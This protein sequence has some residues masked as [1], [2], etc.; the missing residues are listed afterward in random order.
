MIQNKNIRTN[1]EFLKRRQLFNSFPYHELTP[2]VSR[3]SLRHRSDHYY[4]DFLYSVLGNPDPDFIPSTTY[5]VYIEP[6]LNNF[7]LLAAVTDKN[8][9]DQF[10][11]DIR[12]PHTYLRKLNDNFY[13]QT[14]N[15]VDLTNTYLN[16]L[17]NDEERL[18][19]KPSIESGGGRSIMLF[20]RAGREL[21]SD[22]ICL[23]VDL[24][25]GFPD[26]VLQKSVV[27]HDYFRHFNPDSNNT[28][29]ILTYRSVVD[30]RIYLLHRLLRIGRRGSFLDH[31]NLGGIVIGIKESGCL[32]AFGCTVMG[33]KLNTFNGVDFA[34]E[35]KVPF[36]SQIEEMA[37]KIAQQIHYGRLLALDFTVDQTGN[38]LFLEVNCRWNGIDQYQM[39]LGS[40]FGR[41]T[42]EV[43]NY[44]LEKD[45]QYLNKNIG[46]RSS[47]PGER[48]GI[49]GRC[50]WQRTWGARN[51]FPNGERRFKNMPPGSAWNAPVVSR[52]GSETAAFSRLPGWS[53]EPQRLLAASCDEEI[54]SPR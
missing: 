53:P 45:C 34:E 11:A 51:F 29:R 14:F 8:F 24:L 28:I 32:N 52:S 17:L 25:A 31:D 4:Y 50:F 22:S 18:I 46:Y 23:D 40:L 42:E 12:S 48:G 1:I 43:L 30:N 49:S 35:T 38:A 15:R 54:P 47:E 3:S 36:L 39:N 26:F 27:Q 10:L 5:F 21:K 9:Y 37:V 2:T 33:L 16:R 6:L 41:F 44:C 20:T 19:L 13:D 7:S